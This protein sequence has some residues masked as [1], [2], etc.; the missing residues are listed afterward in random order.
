MESPASSFRSSPGGR[1]VTER[2]NT[3]RASASTQVMVITIRGPFPARMLDISLTGCRVRCAD[4]PKFAATVRIAILAHGLE[5]QA[6]QRWREGDISGWRFVYNAEEQ[7]RLQ[8]ILREQRQTHHS[9][10]RL[11]NSFRPR[12]H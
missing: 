11:G 1:V 10:Q 6:E 3:P 12:R 8:A 9:D 7:D 2:R 4:M 5:L